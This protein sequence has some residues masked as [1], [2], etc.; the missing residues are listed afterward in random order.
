[1][2]RTAALADG[3]EGRR[4]RQQ[5]EQG[6]GGGRLSM[7]ADEEERRATAAAELELHAQPVE[8][9]S[10]SAWRWRRGEVAR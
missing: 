3:W 4:R 7:L 8:A 2:G 10:S 5:G 1:M 9:A 6:G